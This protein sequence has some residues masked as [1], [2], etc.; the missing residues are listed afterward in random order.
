MR[1]EISKIGSNSSSHLYAAGTSSSYLQ[2]MNKK[3]NHNHQTPKVWTSN[4]YIE[5][6]SDEL[7]CRLCRRILSEP[8]ALKKCLHRFCAECIDEKILRGVKSCPIATCRKSFPVGSKPFF[9]DRNFRAITSKILIS[10]RRLHRRTVA[11]VVDTAQRAEA[12]PYSNT[13]MDNVPS[14]SSSFLP[15]EIEPSYER[16][17]NHSKDYRGM[18][19]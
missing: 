12:E 2:S 4:N 14:S 10:K 11:D 5:K 15:T 1:E 19:D 3:L 7:Q 18:T 16:H 8:V 13:L 17:A 9:K 6:F